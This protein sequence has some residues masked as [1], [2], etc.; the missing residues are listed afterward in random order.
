MQKMLIVI[1]LFFILPNAN[2]Q[3][4]GFT[5]KSGEEI[6]FKMSDFSPNLRELGAI[7]GYA[8]FLF[9]PYNPENSSEI[10]VGAQKYFIGKCDINNKMVK[11]TEIVLKK[12]KKELQFEGVLKLKDQLFV[13]SSFQNSKDKKHYLF[14]QKFDPVKVELVDNIN[15]AAELDYSGFRKFNGTTFNMEVSPDS[16]K[17]LIFYSLRNNNFE[18]LRSGMHVYNSDLKQLWENDNVTAKFSDGIFDF[19]RFKVAN[20]GAVYLLGEHFKDKSNYYEQAH[21]RSRGFFSADTY[22]TDTPNY[23]FEFYKYS[24]Q[25]VKVDNYSIA[26]PGKFIRS[27]NFFPSDNGIVK[28]IGMY[29]APG[30][31]SVEG[32]FSFDLNQETRLISNLSTKEFG[33][34]LLS[35]DLNQDELKRF[36]RSIDNKQEWDPYDYILSDIKIKQN[37]DKYFIA[38]QYLFGQKK[39]TQRQ[40]Q[41]VVITYD[42]IYVHN[43]LFVVTLN[44]DN[45]IKRIDKINKRQYWLA[46]DQYN[47]Y[48]SI[49]KNNNLYFIYN[50]FEATDA[51]FKNI[52]IGDSYITRL[53][54]SGNQAKS[55]FKKKVESKSPLPLVKTG[56]KVSNG[57]LI[58]SLMPF[59]NRKY[60]FEQV[61][62]TE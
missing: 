50:T 40:A 56:I 44:S 30:K 48:A 6:N 9:L 42:N 7:S 31:I 52:E 21:F 27:I 58:Y 8:Y 53:D 41:S 29:A 24:Q 47:S 28:C 19:N 62:I 17:V 57:T 51:L 60:Q 20:D 26:L 3:D 22:F 18:V 39:V 38:E 46:T 5:V 36:R 43:D 14:V 12:D 25:G 54:M 13:F 2:A 55:V 4:V 1:C 15:L 32:A 34:E 33:Q 45:T 10:V 11:K 37:G 61:I 59:N 49:E 16:T 35:R 23:T